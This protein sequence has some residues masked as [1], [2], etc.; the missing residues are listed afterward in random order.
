MFDFYAFIRKK[1]AEYSKSSGRKGTVLDDLA[2]KPSALLMRDFYNSLVEQRKINNIDE[3]KNMSEEELDFFGN[4]FFNERIAGSLVSTYVRVYFDEKKNLTITENFR[5]VSNGGL[6]YKASIPSFI[7]KNSFKNSDDSSALY[8]IDIYIIAV[9]PGNEYVAEK[10][11]ISQLTNIDFVYKFATNPEDTVGG[12]IHENNDQYYSRLRYSLNDRSLVNKRSL[13]NILKSVFT[14]IDSIYAAGAGDQYMV[15]DL[16]TATDLSKQIRKADYLGK[17]TGDGIV[18]HIAYWGIFPPNPGSFQSDTYWGPHSSYSVYPIPLT[19]DPSTTVFNPDSPNIQA[20]DAAFYGFPLDQESD[21]DMYRGLYFNDYKRY[22]EVKT[23]DLFNILNEN[24]GFTAIQVPNENWKYGTNGSKNGGFANLLSGISSTDVLNF[25]NDTINLA[26]GCTNPIVAGKDILKRTGIKLT[27][28]FIWPAFTDENKDSKLQI[29]LGGVNNYIVD[30]YTGIGFGI[31]VTKG[32]DETTLNGVVYMAHSE[33]YGTAQVF[34]TDQDIIDHVSITGMGALAERHFRIQPGIEYEFEFIL[35]DDLRITLYL[36][37]TSAKIFN[38]PDE[39]ENELHFQ[40]PGKILSIFSDKSR[41]GILAVASTRYGTMMKVSLDTKSPKKTDIWK[42]IGLK[43]FDIN[44]ARAIALFA[45]YVK[46]LEDPVIAFLRSYG[47]GSLNNGLNDGYQAFIWDKEAQ[48]V[49]SPVNSE[50]TRGGWSELSGMTNPDGSKTSVTGLLSH[51]LGNLNR[52]RVNENYVYFLIAASG[53]SQASIRYNGN[54]NDDIYSLLRVE[55]LKLQSDNVDTY[56]SNTKSDLYVSTIKNIEEYKSIVVSVATSGSYFEIDGPVFKILSVTLNG[57]VLS[58]SD[59]TIIDPDPNIVGSYLEK[60][61]IVLNNSTA[62]IINV[63][64]ILYPEISIIQQFFQDTVYGS[65]LIKHKFPCFLSFTFYF[66]GSKT[67]NE[68]ADEIKKYVDQNIDGTFSINNMI[69][70]FYNN[71][72][73]NNIKTPIEISYRRF[74]DNGEEI[75]G[76]FNDTL[77]IRDIDF[78]NIDSLSVQ[79]L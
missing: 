38:D 68:I 76:T 72:L 69:S 45:L 10:N 79:K 60:K 74:D 22:M 50:L 47:R 21:N 62:T 17:L 46:D 61:R 44:P 14:N 12:S 4:K 40:L 63:E 37:K 7:S 15:R 11:T 53:R 52:Y 26:G 34:A 28:S 58:D 24:I 2:V 36:N 59:Y 55:Y 16:V 43:A 30:G 20:S 19:I 51:R 25:L 33:K 41:G 29:M 1:W 66:T 35:Y 13:F 75:A 71:N 9:S 48:F 65:V 64:Y 5:A 31:M 3:Y 78:F 6:Q 49:S 39:L 77:K 73:V 32:Y 8:C 27:G 54:I 42:V 56:H 18:K 23:S 67:I 70:Y 57:E